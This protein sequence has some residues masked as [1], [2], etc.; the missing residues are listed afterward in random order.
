MIVSLKMATSDFPVGLYPE[1]Q[2]HNVK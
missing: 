1:K 2:R